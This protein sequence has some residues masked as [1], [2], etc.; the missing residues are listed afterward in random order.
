MKRFWTKKL[1]FFSPG[2]L[3]NLTAY[4]SPIQRVV[5]D[6]LPGTNEETVASN[7]RFFH[8]IAGPILL[9]QV[10]PTCIIIL[11]LQKLQQLQE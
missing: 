3:D 4:S 8:K 5:T 1:L 11:C 6:L 10:A 7:K 9:E 2:T